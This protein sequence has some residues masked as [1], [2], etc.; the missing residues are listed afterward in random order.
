LHE[1]ENSIAVETGVLTGNETLEHHFT[2]QTKH[3][4][5]QFGLLTQ[6]LEGHWFHNN[7]EVERAIREWLRMQEL[8][9][10]HDGIFKI[11]LGE[12]K[13]INVLWVYN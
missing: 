9:F 5:I 1:F 10:Y 3:V 12:D 7:E 8:Y 4:G 2:P 13:C 11:M 6:H